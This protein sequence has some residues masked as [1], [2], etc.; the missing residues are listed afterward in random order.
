MEGALDGLQVYT[1]HERRN[2]HLSL[3]PFPPPSLSL[4]LC[5]YTAVDMYITPRSTVLQKVIVPSSYIKKPLLSVKDPKV[6]CGAPKTPSQ[7]HE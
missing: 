6:L 7:I 3:S 4:S 5:I 2:H 1:V